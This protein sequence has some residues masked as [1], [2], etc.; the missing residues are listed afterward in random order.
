M[1]RNPL[2]L[3]LTGVAVLCGS[4]AADTIILTTGEKIEGKVIA[5][6]ATELTVEVKVSASVTDQTVVPKAKV[7]KIEKEQLDETAWQ[8]LK[9]TKLGSNSLPVAQYEVV[10]RPLQGFVN[11]FPASPHVAE[12]KKILAAFEEEKK[13][14]EAGEV[15]LGEKW[16][17]SEEVAKERYQIGALLAYQ[18]LRSQRAAGD[19]VGALNSF[20]QLEK[21]YPGAKSYPDAVDAAKEALAALKA[22][23]DRAQLSYPAIQKEFEAGVAAAS[24]AD[25]PELIAA[26]QRELAKGEAALA[27]ADK[28]KLKWPAVVPRSDKNLAAIVQ[29]IDSEQKRLAGLDVSKMRQSVQL[30]EQAQK[31]IAEQK[32]AADETVKKALSLWNANELAKRLQ[33]DAANVKL[34]A[35]TAAKAAEAQKAAAT[36]VPKA[37]PVKVVHEPVA[38]APPEPEK[39]FFLTIGG[40]ITIVVGIAVI[41][42]GVIV[43]KKIKGRGSDVLE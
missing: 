5:E 6:T 41:L 33:P 23:V 1:I 3:L 10:T 40:M 36:P 11:D 13:R 20:D 35:A 9:N 7:L 19:A 37:T 12:A 25:R 14:V 15:R 16:L 8:P 17:T 27:A 42:A 34:A 2:L 26:R 39:S 22:A 30:T 43:F 32:P 31:E 21:N 38:E 24:A 18:Y 29:K 4:A 28:A